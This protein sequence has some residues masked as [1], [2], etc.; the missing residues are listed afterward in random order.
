MRIIIDIQDYR[1]EPLRFPF[2]QDSSSSAGR[3]LDRL[4]HSLREACELAIGATPMTV[5]I[6]IH[7]TKDTK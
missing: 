5:N 1:G 4:K 3:K 2:Y 7:I 6:D